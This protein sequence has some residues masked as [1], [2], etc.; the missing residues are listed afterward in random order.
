MT[1]AIYTQN[2]KQ[3]QKWLDLLSNELP[4]HT[5]EIYPNITSFQEVEML[6]CWKPYNGLI[7]KFSNLKAIQSLGAGVDHIFSENKVDSSIQVS[8]VVDQQLTLDMWE[9]ALAIILGDMKNLPFYASKQN[10]KIWKP[11]RYKRLNEVAIGVLGLGTIGAFVAAQFTQLGCKVFGWS[12]SQK[13]IADITTYTGKDGL[14]KMCAEVDYV[15]NI[16]PLT[17]ETKGILTKELFSSM[18]SS[19]YL[20]NIGRGQHVVDKDLIHSLDEEQIRGAALDVFHFEPLPA[21]HP[22]WAHPKVT[23]TP[24]IASLT[25]INSVYPQV[26]ENIQRLAEGTTMLHRI[27]PEKGY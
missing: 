27:D 9:H 25:H 19:A 10:E 2:E 13:S 1:I 11:R 23:I 8:K 7:S 14:V 16:L 21:S 5:I 22:F 17:M 6:I 4:K 26:V 12:R 3:S 24:H 15:L 18:N 20:I